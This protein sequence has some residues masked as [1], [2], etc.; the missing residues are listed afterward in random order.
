MFTVKVTVTKGGDGSISA[1][2]G[3][4]TIENGEPLTG[5]GTI[6][7]GG[8]SSGG[9]GGGSSGGSSSSPTP[10]AAQLAKDI[11]ALKAGSAT[12]VGATVRITGNTFVAIS[13]ALT[14]PAG[15]TLDVT[16]DGAALGL[17]SQ[18]VGNTPVTLTVNGTVIAG[19]NHVRLEDCQWGAATINGSGTIRLDG[20]GSLLYVEGNHNV[21]NRKII[22]DGVTLVGVNDNS[23]ALVVV[24][25]G[26]ELVLESGAITGNTHASDDWAGGG[27][28]WVDDSGTFTMEGGAITGNTVQGVNG[29]SGG[30][31]HVREGTFTMEA[32][33]I[34]GNITITLQSL[35]NVVGLDGDQAAGGGVHVREGTFTMKG[36]TISGN[37]SQ[38]DNKAEGGGVKIEQS[39]FLMS[40]GTISGNAAL[41]GEYTAEGGG[42]SLI[43]SEF[44][45]TGGAILDNTATIRGGGVIMNHQSTFTMTNGTISGNIVQGGDSAYGG[46]VLMLDNGTFTMKDGAI[47][48][49]TVQGGNWAAGGG[50]FV[51]SDDVTFT[52]EGGTISGNTA[53][54]DGVTM[55][56]GVFVVDDGIFTMKGG[57]IQG[58]TDSE[59][60]TKN[61]ASTSGAAIYVDPDIEAKW[62]TGG[63][64]T[65]GGVTQTGGSDIGTSDDTLIATPVP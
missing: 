55:G 53:Q 46:G 34:S 63:A 51:S 5:P 13:S 3:T 43:F 21:A 15:V 59:G 57:R 24:R 7:S 6:S 39:T 36:G 19:P 38:S 47:S 27:G 11:N 56:G 61:T 30:G 52:M 48:G 16:A 28:V 33:E 2:T 26:G 18:S 58:S 10:A 29:A 62:G 23:E 54:S 20:T 45:M 14:V 40:G 22:L 17:G 35:G 64:Y 8:S 65:K 44:T 32:G 1:I 42:V 12:A 4:I 31:V 41:Q 49:N 9:G 37:T 25:D 60:F 50:V